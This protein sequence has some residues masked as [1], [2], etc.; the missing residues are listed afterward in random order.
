MAKLYVINKKNPT[1][2]TKTRLI[3]ARVSGVDIPDNKR[4]EN[5]SLTYI[6]GIGISTAQGNFRKRPELTANKKVMRLDR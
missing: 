6:F 5:C 3:M 1:V 4:G 2:Q